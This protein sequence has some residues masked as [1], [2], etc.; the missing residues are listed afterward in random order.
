MRILSEL[1]KIT[2]NVYF[3]YA[4]VALSFVQLMGYI[5][6]H[7]TNAVALFVLVALLTYQFSKNMAV[8]LAVSLLCT[9]IVVTSHR[10]MSLGSLFEGLDTMENSPALDKIEDKDKEIADVIPIV[11]KSKSNDEVKATL[12]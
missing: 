4:I 6:Y 3:L 8:V 9:N 12:S 11:K 2:S 1:K 7:Q 5:A 10:L